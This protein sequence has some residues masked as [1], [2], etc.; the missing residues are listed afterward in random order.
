[1]IQTPDLQYSWKDLVEGTKQKTAVQ[2][3][4]HTG[5]TNFSLWA[6]SLVKLW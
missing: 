6:F 1:M 2:R 3:N 4:M 5:E